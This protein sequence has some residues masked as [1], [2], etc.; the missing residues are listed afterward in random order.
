ME[1]FVLGIQLENEELKQKAASHA[2][3]SSPSLDVMEILE[4]LCMAYIKEN[5]GLRS[6]VEGLES[7]NQGLRS[8]NEEQAK[9]IEQLK[10]GSGSH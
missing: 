8:T 3:L 6:T 10:G 9:E 4:S 1:A 7:T 2:P 5:E